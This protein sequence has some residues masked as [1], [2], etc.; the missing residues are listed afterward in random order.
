[1]QDDVKALLPWYV[2]NTLS[3]QEKEAVEA[4]LTESEEAR[5]ELEWLRQ[6]HATAQASHD[7]RS[8]D[9][10]WQRFKRQMKR[11]TESVAESQIPVDVSV[12]RNKWIPRLAVAASLAIAVQLGMFYQHSLDKST[13]Q[14]LSEQQSDFENSWLLQIEFDTE[15]SWQTVIQLMDHVGARIVDGPSP[16]GL[17]RVAIDKSQPE[18]QSKEE[19]IIWLRTQPGI[20]H[21]ADESRD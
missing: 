4:L 3:A 12:K 5:E 6:L 1:M 10:G 20:V 21:V 14:M 2:T 17:V 8:S 7:T 9:L 13:I 18:F 11:E 16:V 15:V 19:L